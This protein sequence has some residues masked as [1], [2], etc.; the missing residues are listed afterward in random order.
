MPSIAA[1]PDGTLWIAWLSFNGNRD[2]VAIRAYRKG[3]WENLQWVPGTSGDSW[4]PHVAVDAANR[5]WV[6]WSQQV[7]STW[8][9][10]ARR[11]DTAANS[12][13]ALQKLSSGP[14]SDI[15]P[16]VWSDGTGKA[17]VVWQ[18]FRRH[19]PPSTRASCNI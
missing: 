3:T 15:N 10:Y 8:D 4:L 7:G 18:G 14:L 11:L 2:D 6:I 12:W 5:V 19:A 9:I 17:A 13:S 1:A 16:R